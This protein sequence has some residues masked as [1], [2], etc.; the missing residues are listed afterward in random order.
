MPTPSKTPVLVLSLIFTM[1]V[2]SIGSI[3]LI[4]LFNANRPD[5]A[6]IAAACKN[7][8]GAA[9]KAESAKV[10]KACE[11]ATKKAVNKLAPSDYYPGF[12]YPAS[13]TV[14]GRDFM[15]AGVLEHWIHVDQGFIY[16]CTDCDGP[17]IP[18]RTVSVERSSDPAI[19][20]T[21]TFKAYI[22]S[23]YKDTAT[24]SNVVVREEKVG[25]VN[26]M[27]ATGHST[28]LW[29]TDFENIWYLSERFLVLVAADQ[30]KQYA[31]GWS[32][33]KSS[34]DFSKID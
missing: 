16:Y 1:L 20:S 15:N 19:A 11:E 12:S 26:V 30:D 4:V 6:T 31:N 33:I 10:T 23:K 5:S 27:V 2:L 7:E 3:A 25:G 9:I 21:P 29:D 24:Y 22:E 34:L 32:I 13:W 17:R 18:I 28:G 8:V 14:V